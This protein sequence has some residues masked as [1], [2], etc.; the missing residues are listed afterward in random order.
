MSKGGVGSHPRGLKQMHALWGDSPRPML[1]LRP[2]ASSATQ[3]WG[4]SIQG[5]KEATLVRW[6]Q[7]D[8][9]LEPRVGRCSQVLG[10][11]AEPGRP[12]W[13]HALWSLLTKP[14]QPRPWAAAEPPATGWPG[15]P[16]PGP[17][18]PRTPLLRTVRKALCLCQSDF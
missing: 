3:I 14:E 5:L 12:C 16:P 13:V 7:G 8:P 15:S 17:P 4:F 10:E 11:R 1:G 6:G 2:S 18:L 9:P